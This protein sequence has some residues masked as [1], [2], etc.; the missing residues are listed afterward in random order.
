MI[1]NI[2]HSCI[3]TKDLKKCLSFYRD[4]LGLKVITQ[5]LEEGSYIENLL[6]LKD[7][8]LTYVKLRSKNNPIPVLEIYYFE[9]GREVN[10]GDFHHIAFTVDNITSLKSFLKGKGFKPLS[11]P[12]LDH[13]KKNLVMFCRD[14]DNNLIEFC[15]EI[16]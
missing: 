6:G 8:K 4:F 13:E 11:E 7:V 16:R 9:D 12:Q 2:R 3:V 15:E 5:K 14:P 10:I 1:S